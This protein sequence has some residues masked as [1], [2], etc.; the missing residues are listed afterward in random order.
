MR[1]KTEAMKFFEYINEDVP[2]FDVT[3]EL[4]GEEVKC[5][6]AIVAKQNFTLAGLE[7]CIQFLGIVGINAKQLKKDG[8]DVK[9]GE[10]I[11]ILEG[12]ARDIL[13]IERLML[14][15]ISHASGI[16]TVTKN[17][18]NLCR[19]VNPKVRVAAT[20]KTLPGLRYL[21][22]KAVKLGGGDTHRMSLSDMILIKDNH[23]RIIGGVREAIKQAKEKSS[24]FTKVEIEVNSLEEAI[25]AAKE[26]ADII[27]L[28]N[29][30]VEEIKETVNKLK[31][32][33]LREKVL[34]EVSGRINE[35]N[36]LDYAACDVDIISSGAIT[37]SAKAVDVSLEVFEVLK[38]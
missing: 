6:A 14:N 35:E 27:M 25:E 10:K 34:I 5:R 37:H 32:L 26:G 3:S 33:K 4:I 17:F 15:I 36:I 1:S 8:E 16:A 30:T 13:S 18:V 7:E 24:L 12:N 20:R 28:D 38:P 9:E 21:E 19:K 22:K 2:F 31:E 29:F 11:A 23:I